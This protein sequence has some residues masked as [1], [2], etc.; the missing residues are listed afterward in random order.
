M[1]TNKCIDIESVISAL[2]KVEKANHV[3]LT[4]LK[5]H[6]VEREPSTI[7]MFTCLSQMETIDSRFKSLINCSS[8][9][10]ANAGYVLEA[11]L[12]V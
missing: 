2:C 9:D 1:L 6:L 10:L 12:L 8:L 5:T 4:A 11:S 3:Q 7:E